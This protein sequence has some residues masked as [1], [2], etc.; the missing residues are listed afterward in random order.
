MPTPRPHR[1]ICLAASLALVVVVSVAEGQNSTTTAPAT[2]PATTQSGKEQDLDPD[3]HRK[4][5]ETF[6]KQMP[7]VRV[8]SLRDVVSFALEKDDIVLRTSIPPT[9]MSAVVV[10]GKPTLISVMT[11]AGDAAAPAA[12][13]ANKGQYQPPVFQLDRHELTPRGGIAITNISAV[14]PRVSISRSSD[15]PNE[16]F[17]NVD[18]IQDDSAFLEEGDERV[19]FYVQVLNEDE[20]VVDLKLSAV[21]LAELRRTYPAETMRYLEPMFREFGQSGVLFQINAKAAWQV[22][23]GTYAPPADVA[24]QVDAVLARLDADDAKVREAAA[25]ELEQLGQP[26]ALA[27]MKRD[28]SKLSEEQLSRIETFLASYKPLSDDEAARMRND[29]EF[30]LMALSSDEPDLATRALDRL[31]EVAKQPIAFDGN[32]TG[33]ARFDAIATLRTQLLPATTQ[34]AT[35]QILRESASDPPPADAPAPQP[36]KRDAA[37]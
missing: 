26:A 9:D 13:A 34:P 10:D 11:Q 15:G 2:S 3:A 16:P 36:P 20:T 24:K 7:V 28:R 32:A 8:E 37:P 1:L 25:K 22:L 29:P 30:L 35:T 23:G 33:A 18:F 17:H 4:E 14:A 19:R 5:R 27:L 31:R 12:P 21:N 6:L